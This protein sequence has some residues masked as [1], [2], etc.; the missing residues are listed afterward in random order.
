LIILDRPPILE[1]DVIFQHLIFD[2]IVRQ[3]T[4][5]SRDR[6]VRAINWSTNFNAVELVWVDTA[7]VEV[8]VVH[9]TRQNLV[10]LAGPWSFGAAGGAVRDRYVGGGRQEKGGKEFS[11]VLHDGWL[12]ISMESNYGNKA[13]SL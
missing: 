10:I 11:R 13:R 12:A 9:Q 5:T 8:V 6:P 7:L 3:T 2:T 4:P 1:I